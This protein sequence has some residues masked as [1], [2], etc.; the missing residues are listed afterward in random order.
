MERYFICDEN[1]T[2]Q[3]KNRCGNYADFL[4]RSIEA[5]TSILKDVQDNGIQDDLVR[6]KLSRIASDLK[7]FLTRLETLMDGTESAVRKGMKEIDKE[8]AFV[9]PETRLEDLKRIVGAFF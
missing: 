6:Q 9:F 8:D 1:E 7:P 4:I 3:A 2:K 5:Y